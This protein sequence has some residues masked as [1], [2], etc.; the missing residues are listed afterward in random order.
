[1]KMLG[2]TNLDSEKGFAVLP[3]I[4]ERYGILEQLEKLVS[5]KAIQYVCMAC[6]LIIINK[7]DIRGD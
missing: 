4:P 1:M 7:K 6:S 3:E 5:R 2:Y